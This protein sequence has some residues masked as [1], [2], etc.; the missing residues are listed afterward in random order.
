MSG[1]R[2]RFVDPVT[3]KQCE[4]YDTTLVNGGIRVDDPPTEQSVTRLQVTFLC[5]DHLQPD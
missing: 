4:S 1:V 3:N 5:S 2:C